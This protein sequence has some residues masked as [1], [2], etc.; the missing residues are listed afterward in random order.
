MNKVPFVIA[1]IC[2]MACKHEKKS[3]VSMS[4]ENEL[5]TFLA[6]TYKT[7]DSTIKIDSFR[8]IRLD[9]ISLK[10]KYLY[11]ADRLTDKISSIAKEANY[12]NSQARVELY[13][14]F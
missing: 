10:E 3:P 7:I 6:E 9:T 13:S 4:K 1:L 14:Y 11:T 5:K 8:F 2:L 12:N